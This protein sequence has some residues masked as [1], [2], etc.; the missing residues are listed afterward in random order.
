[1]PNSEHDNPTRKPSSYTS[2]KLILSVLAVILGTS[3]SSITGQKFDE[4]K[5]TK[6]EKG[7]TTETNLIRLFGKPGNQ[8][9]NAEGM[10]T[11]SWV[12]FEHRKGCASFIPGYGPFIDSFRAYKRKELLVTLTDDGKVM[13]FDFSSSGSQSSFLRVDDVPKK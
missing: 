7:V 9:M 1:M 8:A 6:I 11:L 4:K 13:T 5:V 12:Y 10:T 3:C 2:V